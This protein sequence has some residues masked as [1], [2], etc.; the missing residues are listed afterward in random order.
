MAT[1]DAPTTAARRLDAP[2]DLTLHVGTGKAGSSTIQF[3]MRDNRDAL[4]RLGIL[5]PRTPGGGRH[6]LLGLSAKPPEEMTASPEWPRQKQSDPLEFRRFVR[7][8]LVREIARSGLPR[9]LLS[10]EVIFGSSPATVRNLAAFTRR[11]ASSVR[12]VVY[13]RRQ[14]S[15]MVSRYQE[16][17]KVG[18]LA[19]IEDWADR[20][21]SQLYD[22]RAR[23]GF[24][25]QQFQ[26][27]HIAVRRF[28]R[29]AFAEGSLLQDFLDA[30]SI[31][32]RAADL[33]PVADRNASLDAETVEFLRLLN[34]VRVEQDGAR[35]GQI[36]NR[37]LVA[38]LAPASTGPT[39]TLP[40]DR[41]DAV[42]ARWAESNASVA[43]DFLGDAS[44]ILFREPRRTGNTTVVQRLDPA[45]L[46][47]FLALAE[48]DGRWEGPLRRLVEVEATRGA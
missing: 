35:E 45:R 48:V 44:G 3:F 9:V 4:A 17:V 11:I 10:D 18:G 41:L 37:D 19:R 5:Y 26:P 8:R 16:G 40:A 30:A 24:H 6:G 14:D 36:D 2:V 42:M 47:H 28:E 27:A 21:M 20:D 46:D 13:L 1:D 39:L 32:A 22:Y 23:L 15:H 25:A 33:T 7:R 29:G 43:R 34:R 31:D 38:R 12:L